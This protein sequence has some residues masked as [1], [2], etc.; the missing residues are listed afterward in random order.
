[1]VTVYRNLNLNIQNWN[2]D[3]GENEIDEADD[4]K[5]IRRYRNDV[6]H[7]DASEIKT[8]AFNTCMLDLLG[9]ILVFGTNNYIFNPIA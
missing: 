8:T 6:C 3:P 9:V 1:M 2:I 5:R 7:S 4:I